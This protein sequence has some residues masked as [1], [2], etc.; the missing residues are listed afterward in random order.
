MG[1]EIERKFLV[2]PAFHA[3]FIARPGGERQLQAYLSADPARVVRLRVAGPVGGV[4]S[5]TLTV[6]GAATSGG[7]RRPEWELPVSSAEAADII[8]V[9]GLPA[10]EKVRHR[11][12]FAGLTW[13]V[14]VLALG[15]AAPGGAP[16]HLVVAEVE[17]PD[18]AAV[19]GA[20]LPPWVGV[21]VTG[22]GRFAMA[23]LLGRD[24]QEAAWAAA[25]R[26]QTA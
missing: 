15:P 14:D 24:A 19:D 7:R 2:R 26:L 21:E 13:E 1:V 4:A 18:E 5:G 3:D 9:L 23:A 16:R 8:A 20:A 22:D 25:A 17:A 12:P 11:V 10:L 6:K